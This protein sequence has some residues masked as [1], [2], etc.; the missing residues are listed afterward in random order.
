MICSVAGATRKQGPEEP[1]MQQP[2]AMASDKELG[3]E[4]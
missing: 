3:L 4:G 2:G 1:R